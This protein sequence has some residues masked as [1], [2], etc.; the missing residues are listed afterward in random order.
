MPWD[1]S[2]VNAAMAVVA[3]DG[4]HEDVEQLYRSMRRF[5]AALVAH[6]RGTAASAEHEIVMLAAAVIGRQA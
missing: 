4:Y 3:R 5:R 2:P 6:D 1:W